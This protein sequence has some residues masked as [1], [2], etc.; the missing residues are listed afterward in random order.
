LQGAIA[1]LLNVKPII[2]LRDGVLDASENVRT[3]SKALGRLIELL[4]EHL[5]HDR[6]INLAIIHARAEE[7]GKWLLARAREIFTVQ[8]DLVADLVSSLAVHGGP[9]VVG[10]FGYPVEQ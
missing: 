2:Y 7:D 10:V 6:P 5:G 3:R 4:D 9:G 1:S 8:A